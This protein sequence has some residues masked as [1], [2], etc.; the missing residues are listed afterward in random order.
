MIC[1]SSS[2]CLGGGNDQA[3]LTVHRGGG[4]PR[5]L[6]QDAHKF[7]LVRDHDTAGR[8]QAELDINVLQGRMLQAAESGCDDLV[9]VELSCG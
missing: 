2:Y 7:V 6:F 5:Q 9:Q 4:V 1:L 8:R 3:A